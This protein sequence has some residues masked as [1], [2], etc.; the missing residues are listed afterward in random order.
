MLAPARRVIRWKDMVDLFD[1]DPD[2]TGFDVDVSP[3]IR[4]AEDTDITLFWRDVGAG[5]ENQPP[6]QTAEI[7]AAPIGRARCRRQSEC[8]DRL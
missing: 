2:L 5:V 7:C 1:T 3:Y 4:D 6:P 8:G